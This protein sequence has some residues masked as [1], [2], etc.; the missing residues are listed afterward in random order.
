[1]LYSPKKAEVRRLHID[2]LTQ[3]Q[4]LA[5]INE[6]A[7]L[8]IAVFREYPYL[9]D[10]S[11]AYEAQ[12]LHK[13]SRT[14][15]SLVVVLKNQDGQI[16][17]ALTGLPLI[18]EE[19]NVTAPFVDQQLDLNGVFYIS[20]ILIYQ[21]YRNKGFGKQM[22][23]AAEAFV[24]RLER[25]QRLALATVVREKDHP[26]MPAGYRDS[27]PF[28]LLHGYQPQPD[29]ICTIA[30]Q[31]IDQDHETSQPLMFWTKDLA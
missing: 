20:E 14:S 3:D 1:M 9:Y 11:M 8:R 12:Y 22:M 2:V 6:V 24:Q 18:H 15:D 23:Q 7:R 25:Y 31:Q 19:A 10:G 21:A 13:F 16:V 4:I 29:L 30:W 27:A 5:C 28:W 26:L 17:G